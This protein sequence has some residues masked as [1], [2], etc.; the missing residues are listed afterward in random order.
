MVFHTANQ[1]Q[2][3]PFSSSLSTR[4]ISSGLS[5]FG[6]GQMVSVVGGGGKLEQSRLL[7]EHQPRVD[8][9]GVLLHLIDD[10]LEL[11]DPLQTFRRKLGDT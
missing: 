6:A 1:P 4:S 11:G 2:R 7:D 3:L 8:V 10:G 9:G 5:Y